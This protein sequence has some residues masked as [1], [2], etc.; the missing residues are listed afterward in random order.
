M[1]RSSTYSNA[2]R[3]GLSRLINDKKPASV[4][5]RTYSNMLRCQM[6]RFAMIKNSASGHRRTYSNALRCQLSRFAMIKNGASGHRRT[7]SNMLRCRLSR[8]A[9]II[10]HAGRPASDVDWEGSSI[11]H[12]S[13]FPLH[14]QNQSVAARCIHNPRFF[15]IRDF[16]FYGLV[17]AHPSRHFQHRSPCVSED[18][19][20]HCCDSLYRLTLGLFRRHSCPSETFSPAKTVA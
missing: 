5:W 20:G 10:I 11:S 3:C 1:Y 18:I 12:E 2:H 15:L 14:K 4:G 7:Y 8:F 16:R 9:M 17:L 19:E 6:S 13:R